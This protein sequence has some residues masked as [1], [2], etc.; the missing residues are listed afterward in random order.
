M[1]GEASRIRLA[2]PIQKNVIASM[3]YLSHPS[4]A[5]ARLPI[6][7]NIAKLLKADDA[8]FWIVNATDSAK[9]IFSKA[10]ALSANNEE[11]LEP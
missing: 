7:A 8:E 4:Y 2:E 5:P 10:V 3:R 6:E 11:P 9:T 1:R